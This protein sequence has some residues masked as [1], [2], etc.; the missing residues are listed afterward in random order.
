M[1]TPFQI[2]EA[3]RE[4]IPLVM[5]LM[6]VSGAG[7]TY[8]ALAVASYMLD[9]TGP[10]PWMKDQIVVIDSDNGRSS[11]YASGKPYY[12]SMLKMTKFDPDTW[13]DAYTYAVSKGYKYIVIDSSSDEWQWILEESERMA[14]GE[15]NKERIWG[16]LT[17]K[18]NRFLRTITNGAANVIVTALMK[19]HYETVE[20]DGKKQKVRQGNAPIQRDGVERLFD[21]AGVIEEG[22]TL[23]FIKTLCSALSEQYIDK[24]G[25]DLALTIQAWLKEGEPH[26]PSSFDEMADILAP[27]LSTCASKQEAEPFYAQLM[28]WCTK[29]GL[30]YEDAQKVVRTAAAE[31]LKKQRAGADQSDAPPTPR[32]TQ[33]SATNA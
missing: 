31:L 9:S 2:E 14:K 18:H 8:T 33:Q 27:R 16:V 15:R 30:V 17:P 19:P 13:C 12:F 1:T 29:R 26:V 3:V 4:Q 10:Q 23:R 22:A 32:P 24:P 20:K 11:R 21:I 7:K 6:G 5:L 28:T 25:R